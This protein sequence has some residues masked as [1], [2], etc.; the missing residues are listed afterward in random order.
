[1]AGA[2]AETIP[3]GKRGR[4]VVAARGRILLVLFVLVLLVLAAYFAISAYIAEKLSVPVRVIPTH[5]PADY[6]LS[7]ATVQF[8][9]SVDQI[10]LTGWYIDSPGD[11]V[12]LLLHGRDATMDDESLR[13]MDLVQKLVQQS[14]DVFT[15][16]PRGHGLSG[17]QRYSFGDLEQRDADGALA[18]LKTR[19]VNEVGVIGFSM[20]AAT[21][22]NSAGDH[23]EMRAI[24]ADSSFA[25]FGVL[26]SDSLPRTAG[27]PSFFTPGLFA[28]ARVMYGMELAANK[29]ADA[30]AR[31]GDRPVLLIHETGDPQIATSHHYR[32]VAAGGQNRNLESWLVEGADHAQAFRYYPDEYMRRVLGVFAR[33]KW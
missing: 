14:Y 21:A 30:L 27:V 25:D 3:A 26:V 17:G 24:V 13:V 29:P 19:G 16:D 28:M 11:K 7:Y 5:T 8:E 1:M 18:Y 6:G 10:P 31:L 20:G 15:F 9:S 32:L 23:P 2:S 33:Y 4:S 22:L 12:I